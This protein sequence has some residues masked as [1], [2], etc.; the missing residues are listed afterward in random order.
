M[1]IQTFYHLNKN[2]KF[3][4]RT[5]ILRAVTQFVSFAIMIYKNAQRTGGE[6][7]WKLR[8]PC[9]CNTEITFL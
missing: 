3:N 2:Y 4:L 5:C 6:K 7:Y 9:I 1:L 8:R